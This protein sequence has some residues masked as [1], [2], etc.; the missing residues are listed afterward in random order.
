VAT[1]LTRPAVLVGVDGTEDGIR[2][3]VYGAGEAD[4]R[5]CPVR[6]VHAYEVSAALNPMMPLYGVESLRESGESIVAE[7]ASAILRRYPDLEVTSQVVKGAPSRVLVRLSGQVSLVVLGRSALRGIERVFAGST[8]TAVAARASCPVAVVPTDWRPG[9]G[10]RFVV[11][12][13]DGTQR[14]QEA[15]R[16]GFE[17]ASRMGGSLFAVQAWEPPNWWYTSDHDVTEG[18]AAWS[19]RAHLVL[20]EEL[21]GWHEDFPDVPIVRIFE[22]SHPADALVRRAAGAALL[23]VGARGLGGVPGL[24][25]G[26]TARS[27]LAHAPCPVLVVRSHHKAGDDSSV[28]HGADRLPSPS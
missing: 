2:A 26:S 27:V 13:V 1:G 14:S 23:V 15:L 5:R 25:L 7:A 18:I 16:L 19:E 3:A 22:R 12:G 11:V 6:L 28:P 4:Q 21:A 9:E 8:S 24:Q 17:A 10:Q 20:A